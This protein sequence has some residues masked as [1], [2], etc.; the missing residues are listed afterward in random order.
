MKKQP[1]QN[2][3]FIKADLLVDTSLP[4]YLS[5]SYGHTPIFADAVIAIQMCTG[6]ACTEQH[7]VS[8][9]SSTAGIIGTQVAGI[10]GTKTSPV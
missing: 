2:Q 7:L 4:F 3:D 1:I 10:S 5:M 8:Y 6:I 9:W